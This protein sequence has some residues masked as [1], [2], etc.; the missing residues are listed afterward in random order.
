MSK[1]KKKQVVEETKEDYGTT[2][3]EYQLPEPVAESMTRTADV[4][5][6]INSEINHDYPWA[7]PGMTP[8]QRAILCELVRIRKELSK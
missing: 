5:D 4:V 7:V 3:A 8:Q 6:T 1:A 2:E